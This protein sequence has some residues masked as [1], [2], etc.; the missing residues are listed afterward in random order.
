L[1]LWV[2]AWKLSHQPSDLRE[3]ILGALQLGDLAFA[4]DQFS[5]LQTADPK[6]PLTWLTEAQLDLALGDWS[7][8]LAASQRVLQG[9]PVPDDAHFVYAQAT[10]SSPDPK[11][12]T[13]GVEHLRLLS[14][15]SDLLGLR[16]LRA[17]ANF[18]GNDPFQIQDLAQRLQS[19]PLATRDDKLLALTIRG[20]LPGADDAALE[21]AAREL[22]PANDPD[23][24]VDVG[25]WLMRQGKYTEVL[26]LI[27]TKTA[28]TRKDLF[29]IR[30]D[31]MALLKQWAAIRE[32]LERPNTP[33]DDEIRLLFEARTLTEL[34]LGP[35]SEVAW[36][37]LRLAV[38]NQPAKLRDI[39]IYADRLGLDD[40]ARNAYKS[41]IDDLD[42][43]RFAFE[44]WVALERREQHTDALHN[45]LVTMARYYPSD[46]AVRNDVLYT[47]FLLSPA[48]AEQLDSARKLVAQY[49]RLL[50]YRITLALGFFS[51]GQPAAALNVFEGL[52]INWSTVNPSWRAIF[53]AVLRANGLAADADALKNLTPAASLLPEELVLLNQSPPVTPSH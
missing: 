15:R 7:A 51:A 26:D 42:E 27:D 25:H 17:L 53:S 12:R 3:V 18:P 40:I 35:R 8:A 46:P 9:S 4:T 22:F 19:H 13:A 52:P 34:G 41:L 14:T 5:I 37:R 33:I 38:V 21:N 44:Q 43:R 16:A 32:I 49:P 31:A 24:L 11:V 2:G 36:E 28:F 23:S 1:S 50:S 45:L 29:L 48:T 6:N 47:G 10:Q 39:A 30:L 20:R